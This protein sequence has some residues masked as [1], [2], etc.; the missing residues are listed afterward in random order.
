MMM[1]M[2]GIAPINGPKY[3]ITLVT[4]TMKLTSTAYGM[5]SAL[6]P[7]KHSTP[8]MA[9]SRILPEINPQKIALLS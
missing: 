6:H 7:I 1:K 3:G 8:M 4:P 5:L 2:L 9:E